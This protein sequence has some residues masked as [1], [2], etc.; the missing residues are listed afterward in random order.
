MLAFPVSFDIVV[1]ADLDWGIGKANGL[2]WPRLREDMRHFKR[3]TST[4]SAGRRNAIVMGRK[5]W[6]SKEIDRKP[7]PQRLNVVV[8]RSLYEVPQGVVAVRSL[9]EMLDISDVETLFVI[10]GAGL[11]L[12]ALERSDLRFIYLTRIDARFSCDV[13]MPNL[14]A[15]GFEKDA[16]WD[17]AATHT[18]HDVSYCVERLRRD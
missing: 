10:G 2:P 3:L 18:E 15:E 17:G 16:A 5:T 4:A 7:L 13:Q 6:E 1:A 11:L 12:S 8:S 9:D 14:D